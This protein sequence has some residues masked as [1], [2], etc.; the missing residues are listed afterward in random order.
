MLVDDV[1][2]TGNTFK[3]AKEFLEGAKDVKTLAFN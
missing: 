3:K 2:R 1:S